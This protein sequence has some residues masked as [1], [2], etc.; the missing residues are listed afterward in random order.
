MCGIAGIISS[1]PH[2]F[3]IHDVQ[4]MSNCLSHRGPDGTGAWKNNDATALLGHNRLAIIDMSDA[5]TQPMHYLERYTIV[6]NGEIYNYTELREQLS[7]NGY[8][9]N[10]QS[11]TEVILAAYDYWKERCMQ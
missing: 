2:K 11:D 4:G 9:F 10:S 7:A 3:S 1:V 8:S 6:H 5:A